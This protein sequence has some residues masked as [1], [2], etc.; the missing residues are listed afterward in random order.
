MNSKEMEARSGVARANIRYY[1]AEGLLTPARQKNGYRDYSEEDL[2][3][4][5]KIKLLRRLGVTIEELKALRS[6]GADLSAVLDRRLAELGGER[7]AMARVEQVCGDL[8]RSGENFAEL[9]PRKYL[10]VLDAPALPTENR[11]DWWSQPAAAPLP[12]SDAL[13]PVPGLTRRFFARCFDWLLTLYLIMAACCLLGRNAALLN[14][15]LLGIGLQ[16]L[17]L[18]VE[19]LLICLLGT[20]PGKALLGMRLSRPDGGHLSYGEAFQRHLMMLWSAVGLGIPIWSLVQIYRTVNRAMNE[21]PQP[22]DENVAYTAASF[23]AK[24]HLAGLLLAAA[25][26]LLAGEAVN[27][28][29]Q[30]PPNRGALTV[31][32][33]AENF[34]RQAD[35]Y[36]LDLTFYLDEEGQA[37]EYSEAPNVVSISVTGDWA[38]DGSAPYF[39]YAV[40]NGRLTAVTMARSVENTTEWMGIPREILTVAV[41]AF[42]WGREETPFWSFA[43]EP[44]MTELAEADW[45]EGFTLEE[46]G[47]RVSMETENRG[48]IMASDFGFVFPGEGQPNNFFAFTF[49]MALDK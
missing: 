5:E 3:V 2:A 29:S 25:A 16:V 47:V 10:A 39:Q 45:G 42:Y 49:T 35:Y 41:T 19:P 40:E 14:N 12:E 7:D 43:R 23:R 28:Y 21:E 22:W 18:F 24:R 34:N 46:D 27:S 44:F 17:L 6:G 4:L 13:P 1:E 9:D 37:Q 32:E 33:F 38:E 15:T 11:P 8:R 36:G 48:F 30:L 31:A 20:T 26:L